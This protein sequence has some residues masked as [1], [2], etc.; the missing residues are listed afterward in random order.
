VHNTKDETI[1]EVTNF[2]DSLTTEQFDK[3]AKFFQTSPRVEK[4][5]EYTCPNCQTE[6]VVVMDGLES[7]FG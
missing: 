4:I 3:L 6:N 1:E 7:F 2:V 5:I